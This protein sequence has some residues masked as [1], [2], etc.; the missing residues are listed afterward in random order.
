ML[1]MCLL[2]VSIEMFFI[3][4]RF[5]AHGDSV[6]SKAWEFRVGRSTV[7]SIIHEVCRALWCALQPIYLPEPDEEKWSKVAEGFFN[8]WQ[9]PNCVGAIDGKHIRIQAPSNSGSYWW[10]YKKYFSI[11]LLAICDADYKFVWVDVGQYGK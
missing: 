1:S 2:K 5:L 3:V 7:Y 10:N 4:C 6:N 9:F 8:Q 11:V